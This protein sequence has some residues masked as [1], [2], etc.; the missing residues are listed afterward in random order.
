MDTFDL[1]KYL[2]EN[3]LNEIGTPE[4][5]KIQKVVS[6]YVNLR[7][8]INNPNYPDTAHTYTTYRDWETD[9]KSVV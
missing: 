1:K 3:R 4:Q 5:Q 9:R 7:K 2:V 6:Q 8:A